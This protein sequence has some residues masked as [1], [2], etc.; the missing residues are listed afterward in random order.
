MIDNH[1]AESP[2]L[3]DSLNVKLV[4]VFALVGGDEVRSPITDSVPFV[5]AAQCPARHGNAVFEPYAFGSGLSAQQHH[6]FESGIGQVVVDVEVRLYQFVQP[7][8]YS[9]NSPFHNLGD[10]CE[11]LEDISEWWARPP[12][13]QGQNQEQFM[14]CELSIGPHS[15]WL[16]FLVLGN[17]NMSL[18]EE[19]LYFR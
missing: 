10:C 6:V 18:R 1:A 8:L 19:S 5:N 15:R 9:P 14:F 3:N 17:S 7:V 13:S 16:L 11:R 2:S 4:Q 12:V